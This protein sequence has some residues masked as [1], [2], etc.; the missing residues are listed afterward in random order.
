YCSVS[1]EFSVK[2]S[3]DADDV[4]YTTI[5][6]GGLIGYLNDDARK[7]EYDSNIDYV[8]YCILDVDINVSGN[9]TMYVGGIVGNVLNASVQNSSH[10]GSIN[11][12]AANALNVYVGGIAGK[13]EKVMS[14]GNKFYSYD[15]ALNLK[16]YSDISV[17]MG[18]NSTANTAYVGGIFGEVINC[19]LVGITRS[20]D[21]TVTSDYNNIYVAN[22]AAR[23]INNGSSSSVIIAMNFNTISYEGEVAITSTY[24][25]VTKGE[26]VAY[27]DGV[28]GVS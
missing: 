6:V 11:V 23:A 2:V 28:G 4:A 20:G 22:I 15:S 26:M 16:S 25:T 5:N 14:T 21:I 19:N 10:S 8:K 18:G 17:T 3:V 7:T 13:L 1:G 12:E 27:A 24:G 9:S